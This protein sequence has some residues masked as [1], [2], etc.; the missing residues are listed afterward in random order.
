MFFNKKRKRIV[1]WV[2]I[3]VIVS[4]VSI[5]GC[6]DKKNWVRFRGEQGKGATTNT[7]RPPLGVKWKLQL[8][9]KTEPTYAF[10]NPVVLDDTIYFGST[11]GNI[12]ALD[13]ESGYMRW[14]YKTNGSINSVPIADT[15]NIYI[16]S[17]DG[18]VYA[19]SQ[20]DGELQWRFQTDSTVQS[21]IIRT[22]KSVLFVSDGGH[23]YAVS[24][25]TGKEQYRLPN[26][27]WFYFTFQ[28]YDDVIYFAPG[29]PSRPHSMGAFDIKSRQY[30]WILETRELDAVWYS[31][32]ALKDD[33]LFFSTSD[34]YADVWELDYYAYDRK[35]GELK[36]KYSDFSQFGYSLDTNL[37]ELFDK[38]LRLLDY[39]AP[40]IWENLVIYTSGDSIVR[41]LDTESGTLVWEKAFDSYTTSAPTVAGN[42]LYFGV[43]AS[44]VGHPKG[45]RLV[46]LS[47]RNGKKMWEYEIQGKLLS[48]PV[49]AQDWIIFGTEK[50]YFYVLEALL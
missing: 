38:N 4:V 8:Q 14:V 30:L 25:E 42:Y 40:S 45:P 27:V 2:L 9:K 49:I 28:V 23:V 16:G 41:A 18:S 15:E 13:I 5:T 11:D 44:K 29:P 7:V 47:A 37:N 36:W 17:N 21:T 43:S 1:S 48:A 39:M 34:P 22:Q 35:T 6:E 33:A 31:F 20:K 26:P 3:V 10:N 12:Y 50:N 32:P 19:V 46:C 24:P